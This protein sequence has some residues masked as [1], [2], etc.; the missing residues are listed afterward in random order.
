M[1]PTF[2]RIVDSDVH[3]FIGMGIYDWA[4]PPFGVDYVAARVPPSQKDRV[5]VAHYESGHSVPDAQ[6]GADAAA[7]IAEVLKQ[8]KPAMPQTMVL[9]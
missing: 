9:E 7:F 4:C 8:A 2:L 5:R 6:F 1:L 3:A